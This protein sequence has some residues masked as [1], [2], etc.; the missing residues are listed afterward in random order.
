[1]RILI[2]TETE[3]VT[4]DA[5][6]DMLKKHPR[7]HLLQRWEWGE[8][9]A[10][11]EWDV[12]RL[13][14]EEGGEH[15]CGAQVLYRY[16]PMGVHIGYVPGGPVVDWE[17]REQV[18]ALFEAVHSLRRRYHAMMLKV[19]P[20]IPGDAPAA[21]AILENGLIPTPDTV[22]PRRTLLVDLRG[23]EDD[24]L[25][26]MKQKTRYNIRLASRKG[27]GV[28]EGGADDLPTFHRMAKI[29]GRRDGFGVHTLV[30]YQ[31]AFDLFSPSGDCALLM[32]EHDGEPLA[33][34]MVF[35][36]AGRAYYLFGAST[37]EKRNL[38]P[39]YLLQWEAMRWAK[40][41]GC[42]FYDLWGIPDEDEETLDARFRDRSDGLWGVYRFKRGF[43]GEMW[44]SIG[45]FDYVYSPG[46]YR[47]YVWWK[48]QSWRRASR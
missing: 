34:L 27:V 30:Y 39:T 48:S 7:S 44:R 28:R 32:A 47:M 15:V 5:W 19:E 18:H 4:K 14:V 33:G 23:G 38:M 45:A 3:A 21:P 9:K 40:G 6:D 11:F 31:R 22:Q 41:R 35:S 43:G 8:L 13:L 29:T 1:M 20:C 17:E 12:V 46:L 10:V 16:G 42:A 25:A 26:R 36:H 2:S 37:D 24:V